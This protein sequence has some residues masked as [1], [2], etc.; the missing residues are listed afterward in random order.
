MCTSTPAGLAVVNHLEFDTA[1]GTPQWTDGAAGARP[2][3]CYSVAAAELRCA[4]DSPPLWIVIG[5][6]SSGLASNRVE[7]TLR[8]AREYRCRLI[9][10]LAGEAAGLTTEIVEARL[11][12][13]SVC[14]KEN[15]PLSWGREDARV[16]PQV[17]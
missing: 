10:N 8:L 1:K 7:A 11:L 2:R 9:G 5:A 3:D 16:V 4:S 17:K 14:G 6:P 15:S 13:D 12:H